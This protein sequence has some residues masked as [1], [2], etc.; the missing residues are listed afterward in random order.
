MEFVRIKEGEEPEEKKFFRSIRAGILL[1]AILWLVKF[2]ESFFGFDLTFLGILPGSAVGLIGI[3]TGPFIHADYVHLF[4]NTFSAFIL[5]VGLY[6]F[7][8]PVFFK[9]LTLIFSLSGVLVWVWGREAY[10]IGYSGIIYGIS[11]FMIFRGFWNVNRSQLAVAFIVLFLQWGS[12]FI[13]IFNV[14]ENVSWEAHAFGALSGL[15]VGFVFRKYSTNIKKDMLDASLTEDDVEIE[16]ETPTEFRVLF[17]DDNEE[18][19][20]F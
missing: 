6:Y 20:P 18:K 14:A 17:I 11:F 9:I 10:H 12:L 8:R 16:K 13:G 15:F 3:F 1:I 4:S 5:T 2:S 7:Y 19:E